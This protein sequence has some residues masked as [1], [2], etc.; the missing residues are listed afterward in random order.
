MQLLRRVSD[1]LS[2]RV[3]RRST[4]A[5]RVEL[6]ERQCQETLKLVKGLNDHVSLMARRESQL[7]AVLTS[8]AALDGD[9]ATLTEVL[10]Q[11]GTARHIA[12]TI[13]EATVHR[14]PFPYAV[15]D[16]V[17]PKGLY[18][19]LLKGLPPLELFADRPVNKQQ[20]TVPLRL[21]PVYSQRVWR[22]LTRI[23]VPEFI[24]P[25]IVE[26]LRVPVDEWICQNWPAVQ[27]SSVQF[28]GSDGRILL[29]RRGYLIPP[30]RDPKWGFLTC[31]LYLARREDREAWGTSLYSVDGDGE[32]RGAAPH[33]ID[34]ARCRC[35]TE[36]AFKRN[37]ML[38]FLNSVGAHGAHIP[39]D[40][41]PETLERY[42][43]QFRIGPTVES[44]SLLKAALPEDRRPL[45]AGKS[46]DY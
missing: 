4:V 29:R 27:P 10:A 7:R 11:P 22:F 3:A 37:R 16:D 6:I 13:R 32:A 23:A 12:R 17:L 14:D 42:I 8:D 46:G 30:H 33:W 24:V 35:V 19:C 34:P 25:A 31:I 45:W 20:L 41:Q 18:G 1:R 15:I 9:L 44:M 43:Y 38:V 21:A 2:A 39:E 28:Q 40:A 5:D 36:V 26:K